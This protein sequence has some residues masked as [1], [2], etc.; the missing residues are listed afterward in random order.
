MVNV[1][2]GTPTPVLIFAVSDSYHLGAE[3]ISL[4]KF[5]PSTITEYIRIFV[6]RG[7]RQ[8]KK[9]CLHTPGR[10]SRRNT[11][12]DVL[13]QL[14][15]MKKNVN[16]NSP[17]GVDRQNKGSKCL[18]MARPPMTATFSVCNSGIVLKMLSTSKQTPSSLRNAA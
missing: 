12:V 14:V 10:V 11:E 1:R 18:H 13:E 4:D 8:G 3:D 2:N 17:T 5:L 16:Q 7:V 6:E 9:F 15:Q